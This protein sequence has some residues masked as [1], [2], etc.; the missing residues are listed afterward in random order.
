MGTFGFVGRILFLAS[1]FSFFSCFKRLK[2]SHYLLCVISG[3]EACLTL[4]FIVSSDSYPWSLISFCI[5]ETLDT[6]F[7][8]RGYLSL[9]PSSVQDA[10]G[11]LISGEP[12][13]SRCKHA[14]N[15]SFAG[16]PVLFGNADSPA[17]GRTVAASRP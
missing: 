10:Q 9:G 7:M 11:R 15:I 3:L 13:L 2:C 8:L 4:L 14:P 1:V 12:R 5:L 17:P 6:E 16:H